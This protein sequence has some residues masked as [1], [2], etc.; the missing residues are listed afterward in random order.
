MI[1]RK[2][3]KERDESFLPTFST[4]ERCLQT[5]VVWGTYVSGQWNPFG[6]EGV[7]L[8]V[9]PFRLLDA[10]KKRDWYDPVQSGGFFFLEKNVWHLQGNEKKSF[11]IS[12]D[13][14]REKEIGMSRWFACRLSP[15]KHWRVVN[16]QQKRREKK[17][18]SLIRPVSSVSFR[19]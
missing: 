19:A 5:R 17:R 9:R 14:I 7:S 1:T 2:G 3:G 12:D 15:R 11:I 10:D 6:C 13:L 16:Y 4:G 8:P 18:Q